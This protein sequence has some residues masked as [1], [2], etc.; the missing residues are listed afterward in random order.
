MMRFPK[1]LLL[2]LAA[3]LALG[4]ACSKP[5]T[6]QAPAAPPAPAE[7]TTQPAP[8]QPATAAPAATD[9]VYV[10]EM[11]CEVVNKPGKCPK[12]GMTLLEV[13][14]GDIS[15]TCGTCGFEAAQPGACPKD[16][17]VLTF[18]LKAKS[19]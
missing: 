5:E 7:P 8:D 9:I 16:H 13:R 15:Y 10:C 1:V 18:K 11:G 3:L 2:A 17:T 19:A 12:C 4:L 6:P 14:R